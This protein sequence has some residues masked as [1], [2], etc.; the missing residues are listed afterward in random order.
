MAK[1]KDMLRVA[2]IN[3]VPLALVAGLIGYA[4]PMQTFDVRMVIVWAYIVGGLQGAL[5]A[6]AVHRGR[7]AKERH[8]LM[9]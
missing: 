1:T 7:A 4:K 9:E 8:T 6:Y 5:V 3:L 2:V